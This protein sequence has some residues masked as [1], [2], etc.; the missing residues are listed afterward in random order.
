MGVAVQMPALKKLGEDLG[1][2]MD[3]SVEGLIND[4]LGGPTAPGT[5][6]PETGPRTPPRR[7]DPPGPLTFGHA[8]PGHSAIG[9]A[10]PSRITR[11]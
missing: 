5:P 10:G 1:L 6:T 3:G 4:A 8:H 2:S 9:Q 11:G 7:R